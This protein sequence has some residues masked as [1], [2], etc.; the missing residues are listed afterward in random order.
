MLRSSVV[1]FAALLAVMF[2][3]KKLFKHHIVSII[4]IVVGLFCVGLSEAITPADK[5]SESQSK[6]AGIVILGIC[7]QLAG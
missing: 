7:L 6:A 1:V 3:K 4:A 5:E 2:L